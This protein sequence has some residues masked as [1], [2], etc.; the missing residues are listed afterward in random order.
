MDAAAPFDD[1]DD[2]L[3]VAERWMNE[4]R[5]FAIA[6]IVAGESASVGRRMIVDAEGTVFGR[7]GRDPIEAAAQAQAEAVIGSGEPALLDIGLPEGHAR[8]YVERMG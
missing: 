1:A 8:L 5:D 7:L 3:A 2:V 6:T 4:G